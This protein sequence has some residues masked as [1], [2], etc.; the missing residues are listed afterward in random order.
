[1]RGSV[2]RTSALTVGLTWLLLTHCGDSR[3]E[4]EEASG[5][6]HLASPHSLWETRKACKEVS[7]GYTWFLHRSQAG[8]KRVSK[9]FRLQRD[10]KRGLTKIM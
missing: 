3:R 6:P 1:M 10:Q 4:R 2:R 5:G 8:K 9:K 7:G